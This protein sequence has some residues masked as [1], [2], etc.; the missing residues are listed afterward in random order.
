MIPQKQKVVDKG[1]G[2]CF[3]ACMASFLELPNDERLPDGYESIMPW[4]EWLAKFGMTLSYSNKH[5]WRDGH[6]VALVKSKNYSDG[7]THAIIMEGHKVAFDPSTKKRYR[8]GLD[9]LQTDD[10]LGGWWI[11][12]IDPSLLYKFQQYKDSNAS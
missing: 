11:E 5:I 7:T 10:V 3:R 1:I 8:K 4:N 12:V 6:W 9:L 2:D